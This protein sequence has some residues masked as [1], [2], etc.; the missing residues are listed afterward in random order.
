M[1]QYP[2]LPG[3]EVT[4]A[5]GGLILPEDATTQSV[6]IIAPSLKVDAPVEPVL[7]RQ[8][9]DLETN[10]FGTFVEGGVVNP[11]ASSCKQ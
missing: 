9:S 3:I 4:I 1:T 11:I 7:N 8:S 2:N 10:G 6:L 5:D